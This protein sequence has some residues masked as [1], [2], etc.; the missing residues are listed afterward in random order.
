MKATERR[1]EILNALVMRRESTAENLAAEFGVTER[2]IR[3]DIQELS[4]TYPIET[5]QGRHGGGIKMADWYRP[6]R[7]TLAPEQ[8]DALRRAAA[9]APE[10]DRQVLMSILSQFSAAS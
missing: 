1:A 3:S 7:K 8:A 9:S 2:T 6:S 5:V 10:A 4:L